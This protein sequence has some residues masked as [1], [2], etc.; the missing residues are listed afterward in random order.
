[1]KKMSKILS[2]ILAISMVIS[3][4]PASFAAEGETEATDAGVTITYPLI[5]RAYEAYKSAISGKET[6]V[7]FPC[8]ITY[9]HSGGRLQ[10]HSTTSSF[11]PQPSWGRGSAGVHFSSVKSII[12]NEEVYNPSDE[13]AAWT[14]RVPK[15]GRYNISTIYGTASN[16]TGGAM[17]LLPG[18][19]S[20]IT[21][22]VKKVE[23][24]I[25]IDCYSAEVNTSYE[26]FNKY[27]NPNAS[28]GE[29]ENVK[30]SEGATR[31]LQ[32]G[33][34]IVVWKGY[35]NRV[36]AVSGTAGRYVLRPAS[37]TLNGNGTN[38]AL[39]YA[40]LTGTKTELDAGIEEE[41][42]VVLNNVY[43][44]N[45][46][47][48][49]AAEKEA[50]T[51]AS[52]NEEVAT[53]TGS[54]IKAVSQGKATIYAKNGDYVLGEV[55]I[56]VNDTATADVKMV[57]EFAT[58]TDT[59]NYTTENLSY[60]TT[61][62]RLQY[63]GTTSTIADCVKWYR[64]TAR[65]LLRENNYVYFKINIAKA[66][67]YALNIK[68]GQQ[69]SGTKGEM[70]LLPASTT[71][72]EAAIRNATPTTVVNFYREDAMAY[73]EPLAEHNAKCVVPSAGEY[74]MVWT[75]NGEKN[76]NNM[77]A[78]F[79][80]IITF[81][82]GD[83]LAVM[84]AAFADHDK[85]LSVNGT[86]TVTATGTL[87]NTSSM[88]KVGG[89]AKFTYKSSNSAVATVDETSG[90]V[91]A[92][93][94]GVAKI[95]ATCTNENVID[96]YNSVSTLIAVDEQTTSVSFG[97]DASVDG[98]TITTD[99]EDYTQGEV[100]SVDLNTPVTVKAPETAK[101]GEKNYV[102]RGWVRGN[103]DGGRVISLDAKYDFT[104][105]TNTYLTAIYTEAADEEYYAWNGEFL[106]TEQPSAP[107]VV[108]YNFSEWKESLVNSVKRFVAQYTQLPATY[109]VTYNSNTTQHK[110]DDPV[111]LTSDT[112][113]YWYRDGK[114][115]DYGTSYTFNVWDATEIT[116]SS[117]GHN[118][119][120]LVL[121][122]KAKDGN[123]MV[124]YDANGNQIIE[125]GILFNADA[126]GAPTV[127]S[128]KEK[129]NSQRDLSK[130][131][132]GQFA[133]KAGAYTQARG[134]LVYEDNGTYK[135]IY[136]E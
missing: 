42:T 135:V 99:V 64:N 83:G 121:D 61:G 114:L 89:A 62:G 12:E 34:Y 110:Y 47:A 21:D 74:Y 37:I 80:G 107:E 13:Y 57:Y 58:F 94:G 16:G 30:V 79:L 9:L 2:I 50:I 120:M 82:G 119:P 109:G 90:V 51:Y 26:D 33:E 23:P 20:N 104:A 136:S 84:D 92:V 39:I 8:E 5:Q 68:H 15:S 97:A 28:S 124:E 130:N 18:D 36:S 131:P 95:T 73:Q 6:S 105:M 56:T 100:G 38:R 78:L 43:M 1:M 44:S 4:I 103:A 113:V 40:D 60:K 7:L 17:Y 19:T 49:T 75:T 70:Y 66:G 69:P 59:G 87:S 88:L 22:A 101:V 111:T 67:K 118:L 77:W 32:E 27:N 102:F 76:S 55:D 126:D 11:T 91:T 117:E 46:V 71:D 3:L 129:M 85:T 108:G 123:Y 122:A 48:A 45:G 52:S 116:T 72:I 53:V 14:I 93:S 128:C 10:W 96:G 81:D 41:T 133:A 106:G 115:V 31:E 63:V 132:H 134:Y 86:V 25:T 98:I 125:V 35:G 24:V 29:A 54:T 112:A 65:V 127:V